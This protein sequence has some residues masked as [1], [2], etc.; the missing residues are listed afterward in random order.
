VHIEILHP[1]SFTIQANSAVM[2]ECDIPA[3]DGYNPMMVTP[4]NYGSNVVSVFSN[5]I[6]G[7]KV[8][9]GYMNA[10]TVPI[11]L[12]NISVVVIYLKS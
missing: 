11:N 2:V 3:V 4:R 8:M 10:S 9:L 5:Y 1:S 12:I 7:S 6:N